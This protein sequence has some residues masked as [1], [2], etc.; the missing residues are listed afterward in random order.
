MTPLA[1]SRLGAY[2]MGATRSVSSDP[3]LD[4]LGVEPPPRTVQIQGHRPVRIELASPS[5]GQVRSAVCGASSSGDSAAIVVGTV[6]DARDR[7]PATGVAVTGEWLELSFTKQG[8]VRRMPHLVATTGENGWFAL[9]NVPAA[10]TMALTATR[11]RGQHGSHRG[12]D[13]GRGISAA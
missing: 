10:G 13:P 3:M 2:R 11:G 1:G 5:V 12:A 6:R 7:A 9:C 8:L 4:S